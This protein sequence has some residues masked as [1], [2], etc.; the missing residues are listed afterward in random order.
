M[1]NVQNGGSRRIWM[2][3]NGGTLIGFWI[4]DGN[5]CRKGRRCFNERERKRPYVSEYKEREKDKKKGDGT[6][7]VHDGYVSL[8][9]TMTT[10][11]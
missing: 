4:T 8:D 11:E 5:A 7:V 6:T 1:T 10:S 9:K 3:R 2:Q